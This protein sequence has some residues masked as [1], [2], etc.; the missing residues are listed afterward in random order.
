MARSSA[1]STTG[2][3]K[4]TRPTAWALNSAVYRFLV[5][6]FIVAYSLI[7]WSRNLAHLSYLLLNSSPNEPDEIITEQYRKLIEEC[8]SS[9]Y[10]K[11]Q[12]E[13]RVLMEAKTKALN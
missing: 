13:V 1:T 3:P 7:L 5:T 2:F 8:P 10:C 11:S 4:P 6:A 9:R 12:A